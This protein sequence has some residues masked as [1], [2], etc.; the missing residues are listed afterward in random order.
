LNNRTI[1]GLPAQV[2]F[3]AKGIRPRLWHERKSARKAII[4]NLLTWIVLLAV[5]VAII[6]FR[7][8]AQK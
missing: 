1:L 5:F 2:V 3:I 6:Y 4:V 7:Q 8:S